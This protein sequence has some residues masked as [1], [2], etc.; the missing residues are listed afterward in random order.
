MH[1]PSGEVLMRLQ[2]SMRR[3][4]LTGMHLHVQPALRMHFNVTIQA[5]A[6]LIQEAADLEK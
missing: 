6:A 5:D 3:N 4:A 1:M 2:G